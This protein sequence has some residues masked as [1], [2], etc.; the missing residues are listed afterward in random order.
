MIIYYGKVKINEI[1]CTFK[2]W[3]MMVET[4]WKLEQA[5]KQKIPHYHDQPTTPLLIVGQQYKQA[6][7]N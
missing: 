3:K 2:M 4:R 7:K 5:W 6:T 1:H